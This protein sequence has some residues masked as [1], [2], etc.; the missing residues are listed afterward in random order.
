MTR[1]PVLEGYARGG[2]ARSRPARCELCAAPLGD[3]I[4]GAPRHRHVLERS[5][6]AVRCACRA[7]A[8]LFAAGGRYVTIPERVIV[9]ER[10]APSPEAWASLR[11]PVGLVAAVRG[12]RPAI[13]FPSPAGAVEG[14]IFGE[15]WKALGAMTPLLEKLVPDV[16]ALVLEV[17][18]RA[19]VLA[20][21]DAFVELIET[22]RRSWRGVADVDAAIDGWL[23][24]LK[25]G[26]R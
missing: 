8:V 9:D 5:S 22:V 25:R 16:E 1:L 11:L 14:E 15:T 24:R 19:A 6:R 10:F 26:E 3:L 20:P 18:R 4:D 12:E 2:A 17:R 7:C 23:A 13:L 21:I